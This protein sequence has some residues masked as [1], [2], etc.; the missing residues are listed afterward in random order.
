MIIYKLKIIKML[1]IWD[2]YI[3][4]IGS[5]FMNILEV[6]IMKNEIRKVFVFKSNVVIDVVKIFKCGKK[7]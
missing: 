7:L 3:G 1:E 2:W 4:I 5:F 6:K